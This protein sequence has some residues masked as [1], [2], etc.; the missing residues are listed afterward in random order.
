MRLLRLIR[1]SRRDGNLTNETLNI[2]FNER[3]IL[4]YNPR[5]TRAVFSRTSMLL[6]IDAGTHKFAI[7]F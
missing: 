3:Y 2:L 4:L 6:Y 5:T 1:N 7:S